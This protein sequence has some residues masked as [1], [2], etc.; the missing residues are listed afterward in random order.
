MQVV[1]IPVGITGELDG[2]GNIQVENMLVVYR[3]RIGLRP[4][5]PSQVLDVPAEKA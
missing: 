3:G 1:G 4:N 2:P 5:P